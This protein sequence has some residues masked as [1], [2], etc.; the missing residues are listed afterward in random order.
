MPGYQDSRLSGRKESRQFHVDVDVDVDGIRVTSSPP[1]AVRPLC[2][3]TR[4]QGSKAL[5][6]G[7]KAPTDYIHY[8]VK[9]TAVTLCAISRVILH[10]LLRY[11]SCNGIGRAQILE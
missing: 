11:S 4:Q 8:E 2:Q 1:Q 7:L 6:V 3:A 9:Y 10:A 5:T